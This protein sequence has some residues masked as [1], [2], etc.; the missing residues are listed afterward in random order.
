MVQRQGKWGK[1]CA[2]NFE[3]PNPSWDVGELGKLVC[4]SMTYR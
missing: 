3:D 1:L 4:K 2:D